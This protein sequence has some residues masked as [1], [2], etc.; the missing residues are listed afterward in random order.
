MKNDARNLGNKGLCCLV[1]TVSFRK[2]SFQ[3]GP[4]MESRRRKPSSSDRRPSENMD[5]KDKLFVPASQFY[6]RPSIASLDEGPKTSKILVTTAS[7]STVHGFPSIASS[8]AFLANKI[9]WVVSLVFAWGYGLYGV[10]GMIVLYTNYEKL[11]T[12]SLIPEGKHSSILKKQNTKILTFF[13]N[14]K[15]YPLISQVRKDLFS[16]KS[17]KA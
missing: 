12:I 9:L 14:L 7:K 17:F 8:D 2:Q 5:D 4:S 16:N 10:Y 15:K 13:L 11:T 1:K 3:T 6:K